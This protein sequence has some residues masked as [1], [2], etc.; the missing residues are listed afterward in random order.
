MFGFFILVGSVECIYDLRRE[1]REREGER[2]KVLDPRPGGQQ[3]VDQEPIHVHF[4]P[5][6]MCLLRS[7][8]RR[9]LC[10]G[11]LRDP[12]SGKGHGEDLC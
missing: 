12:T 7:E 4:C 1:A 9:G 5:R 6:E 3:R 8:E 2:A 11:E 10:S